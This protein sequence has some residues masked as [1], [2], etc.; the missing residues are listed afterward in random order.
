MMA[1]DFTIDENAG[2]AYV[3]THRQNTIERVP[4]DPGRGQSDETVA[5]QPFNEQLVGLS[6]VA[7][8]RGSNDYGSIAYVTTD[9]GYTAPPNGVVRTAKVLRAQFSAPS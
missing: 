5:G 6:S 4:L 7:W 3:T 9:G 1:D 8:A 2:V